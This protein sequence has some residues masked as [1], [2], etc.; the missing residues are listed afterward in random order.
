MFPGALSWLW[1][2]I[3]STGVLFLGALAVLGKVYWDGRRAGIERIRKE[4]EEALERA[5]AMRQE[6]TDDVEKLSDDQLDR[7][8]RDWLRKR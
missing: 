5:K 2:K 1:Q 4:Q 6:L 7:A 3:A 8:G